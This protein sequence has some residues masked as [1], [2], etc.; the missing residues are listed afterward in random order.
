MSEE[1]NQEISPEV[2]EALEQP[3]Q[4]E[5]QAPVEQATTVPEE[6]KKESDFDRNLRVMRERAAKAERERDELMRKLA[7]KEQPQL[8]K[9]EEEDLEVNLNPDDLAEGKHLSKVAKK[10]RKLEEKLAQYERQSAT[11]TA[12]LK[13]KTEMPD[14][15][16][17]VTKENI[18][19]L[20][21]SYPELAETL[22]ANPDMYSKA[23][24]AYTLIKRF[25]IAP[26]ESINQDKARA[27]KNAS[28]P[29][30]SV[31]IAKTSASPLS[32]VNMFENGLTEEVKDKLYKEMMQAINNN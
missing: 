14:F 7:E 3:V 13:L 18:E 26:D 2:V 25:G 21:A 1:L 10:I 6:P 11:T 27:L 12:E 15:D 31:A 24:S 23:K 8:P 22:A 29:V 17:V 20:R 9:Q 32:Q 16:N 28:K 19:M 4:Q 5:E 30:P